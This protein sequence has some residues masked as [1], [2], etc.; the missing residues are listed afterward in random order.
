MQEE[1]TQE[2]QA[3]I[4]NLVEN[5]VELDGEQMF[6][7]S[8][9]VANAFGKEHKDVL[10]AI[11]NLECSAE[12][13]ERNFAPSE[14][15]DSTGRTLPA[16]RITRDGFAFL[17][18][19]FTGKRAAAWKERFLAAFNAMEAEL[20]EGGRL[21]QIT[22]PPT[23]PGEVRAQRMIKVYQGLAALWAFLDKIPYEVARLTVCS[24]LDVHDLNEFTEGMDPNSNALN[25]L[26]RNCA[27]PAYGVAGL[28]KASPEK[29]QM[30][31]RILEAC[32]QFKYS[33]DLDFGQ[34]FEGWTGVRVS[35]I[36]A[37]NEHDIEKMIVF[38][39]LLMFRVLQNT[40]DMN[41]MAELLN[42]K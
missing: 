20:R 28:P 5:I 17:A 12:F 18:M 2:T 32:A 13:T 42:G 9:I 7:T 34:V 8:L 36:A 31:K 27:H 33:R 23:E 22:I 35:D 14:Y 15:K 24:L 26:F 3:A 19:G 16:Y 40:L 38:S 30:L 1:Q 21:L 4:D 41:N 25:M 11:S 10:K 37:L 29:V 39:G 6:T